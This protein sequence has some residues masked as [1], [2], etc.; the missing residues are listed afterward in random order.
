MYS[1]TIPKNLRW[2]NTP[3]FIKQGQHTLIA[4]PKPIYKK[5]KLQADTSDEYRIK[6]SLT[7]Y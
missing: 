3:K 5:R 6:K 4:K 7:K 2:G 1:Q